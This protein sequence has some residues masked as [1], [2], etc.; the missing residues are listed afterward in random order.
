LQSAWCRAFYFRHGAGFF[1]AQ[2]IKD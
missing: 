2:W 1:V